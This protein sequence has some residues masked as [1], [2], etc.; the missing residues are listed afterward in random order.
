MNHNRSILIVDDDEIISSIYR[1]K[2]EKG[3]F[4][5]EVARDGQSGFYRIHE[6]RPTVVLLDLMLP[7]MN[8]I[9]VL[10]KIKAQKRF[11]H[12][13]VF[14]FTNGYLSETAHEAAEMGADKVFNKASATPQ[15]IIDSVLEVIGESAEGHHYGHVAHDT[16]D[17]T[18]QGYYA[19]KEYS[20]EP[21]EDQTLHMGPTSTESPPPPSSAVPVVPDTEYH[22]KLVV[23]FYE[24]ASDTISDLRKLFQEATRTED[25]EVRI[26]TLSKL[27]GM[28]R[29]LTGSA[30][31]AGRR[32]F[33]QMC[34][35]LEALLRELYEKPVKINASSLRTVAMSIDFLTQLVRKPPRDEEPN[36][37]PFTALVVDDEAISRRAVIKALQK[38]GMSAIGVDSPSV[39]LGIL[40][41]NAFDLVVLDVMMPEMDGHT[42]CKNL[43]EI[44]IHKDVPVVFVTGLNDFETRAKTT[45]SGGNDMIAKPFLFMELAVKAL[46]LVMKARLNA[47]RKPD[48]VEVA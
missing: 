34:S 20:P 48:L 39:A 19:A 35:A 14:V 30:A 37:V 18:D 8:G 23:Q 40:G 2:F 28:V 43:R 5:V 44:D 1:S 7:Q 4:D 22:A 41:D 25:R 3:G 17:E 15:Q 6:L 11:Q 10:K 9:D 24:G 45:L 36:S 13:P 31:L 27:Y 12:T 47:V 21:H 46:T 16:N 33:A 42:L 32:V 29:T 26:E 38:A